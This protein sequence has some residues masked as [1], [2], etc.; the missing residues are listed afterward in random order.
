MSL[1]GYTKMFFCVQQSVYRSITDRCHLKYVYYYF[2]PLLDA[3]CFWLPLF[4][5]AKKLSPDILKFD[6]Q[7]PTNSIVKILFGASSRYKLVNMFIKVKF[8]KTL[9][10]TT[11]L[12]SSSL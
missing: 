1:N 10:T 8:C 5:D 11:Q 4:F 7:H 6:R 3:V 12:K 9:C 2:V